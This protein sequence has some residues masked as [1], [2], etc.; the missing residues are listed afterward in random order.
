LTGTA[1]PV[2]DRVTE[3]LSMQDVATAGRGSALL[4]GL[5]AALARQRG[6][7]EVVVPA[8]CC[9]TVALAA[10]YA[11]HEVRVA[12]VSPDTLCLTE[13]TVARVLSE[14][15][16]A[17]VVVHV[18][19]VDADASQFQHLRRAHPNVAFVEDIAHA[20]GGVNV[21][22]EPLGAELD[23]ALLS[24]APDKILPGDGGMLASSAG[25]LGK[26]EIISELPPIGAPAT[27]PLLALSLRN[28]VHALADLWRVRPTVDTA[29]S[30][31]AVGPDYRDLI[32]YSG[33]IGDEVA[34]GAALDDLA[35]IQRARFARYARYR[36]EI[37]PA[38]A[39]VVALHAGSTC[40]RC[41]VLLETPAH[42]REV[43]DLLRRSGVHASNHY[44]PLHKLFGG[45]ACP[46]AEDL[47]SR[48]VCL[49]VDA[50]ASDEMV[51][52][53]VQIINTA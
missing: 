5:F 48:I 50:S 14:R 16:R 32:V 2:A 47:A 31:L 43:T 28:L 15:T 41:P 17:V 27:K 20:V 8:I 21:R 36:D 1:G 9:E 24:F 53:A 4:F 42:T 34:L 25:A 7:G 6:S 13:D 12:D 18:Y 37:D 52:R 23:Y 22:G 29:P 45:G 51:E 40:W 33:R 46:N 19:G 3:L 10:A 38:K 11:G 44:F 26:D 35:A 39:T 30:F 49:W